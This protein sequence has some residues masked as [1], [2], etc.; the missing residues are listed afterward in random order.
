[1]NGRFL[2][3]LLLILLWF[4][5]GWYVFNKY[6]CGTSATDPAPVPAAAVDECANWSISDG[7][8]FSKNVGSHYQF[9]RSS[10]TP[11][12]SGIGFGTAI[13]ATA[14][15]LKANTSR[16]LTI[17]GLYDTIETNQSILGNLGLA[18]ANAIKKIFM[19]KGVTGGQI[20]ITAEQNGN[21]CYS[22]SGDTL[23][24]GALFSF[25]AANMGTDRIDAIKARLLGK[26]ITLYFETNSDNI[27]LSRQQRTDFGDLIYYLDNVSDSNLSIAG[28]T[29]I[30]GNRNSNIELSESRAEFVK[31]YLRRNGSIS[32]LRMNTNGYGP[33]RP[34]AS[35]QTA[36]GRGQN[37]RVEVTL[38]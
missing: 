11:I 14:D 2:T 19:G 22:T 35:N 27:A 9:R 31:E 34:V 10:F 33:D 29:D 30:I 36:E 38:N 17:T 28:H 21:S 12:A 26:P 23:R 18:R 25:G 32:D 24:R 20:S 13:D 7:A 8:S 16:A 4:L 3:I 6:V 1:M 15:Y 5:L 37:R